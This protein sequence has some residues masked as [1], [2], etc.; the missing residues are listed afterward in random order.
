MNK[1]K[2]ILLDIIKGFCSIINV[3]INILLLIL[4][5]PYILL[6]ILRYLTNLDLFGLRNKYSFISNAIKFIIKHINHN[7]TLIINKKFIAEWYENNIP[8]TEKIQYLDIKNKKQT[9]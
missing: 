3:I 2:T 9:R 8:K 4:L 6:D 5:I 7:I 1:I